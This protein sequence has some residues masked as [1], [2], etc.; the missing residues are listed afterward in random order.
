VIADSTAGR[1]N[2]AGQ[3]RSGQRSSGRNRRQAGMVT[4]ELAFATLGAAA[5]LALL[6][7]ALALVMLLARCNDLAAAVAR[8]EARGDAAAVAKILQQRPVG[9]R[10]IVRQESTE[11]FVTVELAARPWADWLPSVPLSATATVL[12]EPT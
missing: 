4:A 12:R 1:G 7:W 9:A 2:P 11:I 8:Q 6:A 3:A 10:V 5:A